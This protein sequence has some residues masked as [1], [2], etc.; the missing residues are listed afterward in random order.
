MR[1]YRLSFYVPKSD[2]ENVKNAVFETGAGTQ[3]EYKQACWQVLGQGQF[4]PLS[5][6]RP[7][8]GQVNQLKKVEEYRVEILCTEKN[9]SQAVV[10]LKKAHPYEEP[11][12]SVIK[13]E[14]Y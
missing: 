10:A 6:A 9:I 14:A 3:G 11:A 13:L 7:T 2:A 8:I 4:M 12:Y 5:N 1:Q